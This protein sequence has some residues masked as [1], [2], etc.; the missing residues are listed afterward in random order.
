MME[1]LKDK[2]SRKIDYVR[3]SITDRCDLR[4]QYCMALEQKFAPKPEILSFEEIVSLV[5]FL[6]KN[7]VKKIRLTG[8][9]PMVRKDF[10]K[11]L[12][13][14]APFL[15][16]NSLDEIALTTNGTLLSKYANDLAKNHIKRINVSID[17]LNKDK[18]KQITRGGDLSNV[19]YG[20]ECAKNQGL[21][22][23]LNCV[24]IRNFN[25]DEI[26]KIIEFA[27][28]NMFDIS[29]IETMP[30]DE[31]ILN[32]KEG[33]ISAYEIKSQLEKQ[34][35][36]EEIPYKT[37]GPA[38]YYYIKQTKGRIGFISPMSHNFCADCNRVRIS[39][40]GQLFAC[41]GHD[42]AFDLKTPL[43]QKDFEKMAQVLHNAINK[44][45]QSHLFDFDNGY[46]PKRPMSLTGG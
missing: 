38:R 34:W 22:I 28:E 44:K 45:P 27:H 41:L 35:Q 5:D 18:Y 1:A 29:L 9:E 16:N 4:C 12:Y 3:L 7:G 46:V 20:L 11:L 23:K 24:L 21:K 19:L 25:D 40:N 26:S 15:E 13:M 2:Y 36:L 6:S 31:R 30:L 42:D 14:L 33:Y 10:D 39:A 8:G 17:S 32:R 37:N 43:K